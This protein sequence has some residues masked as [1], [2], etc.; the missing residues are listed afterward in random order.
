MKIG[1]LR[2]FIEIL[3]DEQKSNFFKLKKSMQLKKIYSLVNESPQE[4]KISTGLSAGGYTEI[5]NGEIQ[6]G[7]EIISK[8]V[9]NETIKKALRLF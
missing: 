1:F 3:S 6:N 4:I 5:I 7:D 8:I 2:L 9:V